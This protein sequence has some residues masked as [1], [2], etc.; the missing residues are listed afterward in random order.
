MTVKEILTAWLKEHGYDGLCCEVGSDEW[1]GCTLEDF[2]P[3]TGS[4]NDCLD[5][6]PGYAQ[7]KPPDWKGF[8]VPIGPEKPEAPK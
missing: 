5:C 3:C 7:E 8:G 4:E 6:Q 1:C 2:A